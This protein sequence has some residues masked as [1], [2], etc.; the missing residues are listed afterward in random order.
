MDPAHE[1]T[2]LNPAV[3]VLLLVVGSVALALG[4]VGV[5]VPVLPTT[6]FLL[7]AAACFARA[8]TRLYGWLLS[9]PTLGPIVAEWRRSRSLPPGVKARALVV[10]AVTF[11][12]SVVFVDPV[13]LK[14]ALLAGGSVLAVFLYR[15]PTAPATTD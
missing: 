1:P 6:P 5:F 3:R 14:I 11:T 10:V 12:L 2:P 7:V 8:S 15:L 4:V 9:Q 13:A